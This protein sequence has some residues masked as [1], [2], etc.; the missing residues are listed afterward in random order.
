M[1]VTELERTGMVSDLTTL[2][3]E[4]ATL[5]PGSLVLAAEALAEA[6][7]ERDC[8]QL[9]RQG[10][11]RPASEA[12]SI[13]AEL[14]SAGHG[15]EAVTL[16]TALVQ[17]RTAEEAARAAANAPDVVVPLLL[18]AARKVSPSHH[19]AVTS[20]LRRAGVA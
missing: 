10:A 18:D 2:L 4:A 16:L 9:L 20:E 7:R 12:G 15:K 11:A 8:G 17:A 14:W 5:P 1:L 19:Y 6:G 13:A 3:W